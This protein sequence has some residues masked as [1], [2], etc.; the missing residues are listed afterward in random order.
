MVAQQRLTIRQVNERLPLVQAIVRD[1]VE[2]YGDIVS[3]KLRLSSVHRRRPAAS[4]AAS[5]YEEEVVQMEEELLRDEQRLEAWQAELEQVGGHL[6]N[7][8]VG[9]VDFL[10]ELGGDSVWLCWQP[11]EPS[12][13]YWHAGSC[14]DSDRIPLCHET[15]GIQILR[16]TDLEEPS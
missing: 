5:V 13:M 10:S 2:L 1:I 3:R 7:A 15:E 14:S 6:T 11:G 4:G 8:S 9:R 16:T 12:V